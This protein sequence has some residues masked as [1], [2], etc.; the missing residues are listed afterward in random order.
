MLC[1]YS[2][3]GESMGWPFGL[4]GVLLG[5]GL[6]A[7]GCGSTDS[8]NKSPSDGGSVAGGSGGDDGEGQAGSGVS[9][10]AGSPD[11]GGGGG[12]GS[13]S[14]LAGGGGSIAD[15]GVGGEG[16]AGPGGEGGSGSQGGA[17][18][19]GG[20]G[21]VPPY[22]GDCSAVSLVVNC[23]FEAPV[24]A[25]GGFVLRSGG[26]QLD[27]WTVVGATGNVGT[28]NT[29]FTDAGLSWPA[30]EQSQ[31]LDLTGNT[32]SGTGV[33]QAIAT[34][35]GVEYQLS[36][37]SGNIS[38]AG[39]YGTMSTVI[40]RLDDQEI[41]RVTNSDGAGTTSLAWRQ[42]SVTFTAAA[43]SSTIAFINGDDA[44]DNSNIID[45]VVLREL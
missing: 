29:S 14:N 32:T 26:Q 39:I 40:V 27:G 11:V 22:A 31:T 9:P 44:G 30:R 19:E 7:H 33:S 13:D 24:A 12:G 15:G 2:S 23:G 10:I 6:L 37:W 38:H 36:F 34:K 43:T 3:D 41:L 5:A 45:N 21:S 35:V 1:A 4:G 25:M 17:G 42:V 18:G 16:G 8:R 20:Q 28:L